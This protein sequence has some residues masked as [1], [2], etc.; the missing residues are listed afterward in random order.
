[1]EELTDEALAVQVQQGSKASFTEL[2]RRFGPRLFGF[3][4]G[5]IDSNEDCEDLVQETLVKA[6]QNIAQYRQKWAFS[7]WLFTIGARRTIDFVRA[8]KRRIDSEMPIYLPSDENP[9]ETAVRREENDHLWIRAKALPQ[10]Q[11]DALYLRYREDLS[12]KE[13]AR[14]L[15]VTRVH[16]KVLLYRARTQLACME[17][18]NG[19]ILKKSKDAPEIPRAS[20]PINEVG[21]D[22]VQIL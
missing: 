16:V 19:S 3:F 22:V 10:K 13:I 11:Y 15:S 9:V 17:S 20:Y 14:V 21:G 5:K 1:M 4:R 7:T 8:R 18:N 2:V 6:Y 12:I